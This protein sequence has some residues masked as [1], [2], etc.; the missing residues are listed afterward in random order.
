MN[1]YRLDGKLYVTEDMRLIRYGEVFA[2]E[3]ND[4]D[5]KRCDVV[6]LPCHTDSRQYDYTSEY[7]EA[8]ELNLT[9]RGCE[10]L[11]LY[12][13]DERPIMSSPISVLVHPGPTK[14]RSHIRFLIKLYRQ[15]IA[16]R[17]FDVVLT[18][19]GSTV[20]FHPIAGAT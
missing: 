1:Y 14:D 8:E 3:A 11:M 18:P 9:V 4:L 17:R 10:F 13:P 19:A 15:L 16:R 6:K 20:R 7:P 2:D 12:R 5:A